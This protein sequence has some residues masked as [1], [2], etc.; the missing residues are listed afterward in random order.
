MARKAIIIRVVTDWEGI[1]WDAR[2]AEPTR[3]GFTAYE[4]WPSG[5]PRG[6]NGCGGP[7]W[8]LT[9]PLARWLEKHRIG[10]TNHIGDLPFCLSVLKR[11]RKLLGHDR[12]VDHRAWWLDRLDDLDAL[13]S[14]DF[15]RRHGRVS[16][17]AVDMARKQLVGF[18]GQSRAAWRD[19]AD[20][21][22]G[23][24]PSQTIAA[25]L[26]TSVDVVCK[27]R[28]RL[29]EERGLPHRRQRRVYL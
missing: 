15:V 8:I 5:Y 18:R 23:D 17:A 6:R 12:R 2:R 29:E 22:L 20:L 24:L 16:K 21:I 4:G 9:R 13:T 19:H 27:M 10:A 7:A 1:P 25:K 28:H 11:L 3:L 26:A 14:G